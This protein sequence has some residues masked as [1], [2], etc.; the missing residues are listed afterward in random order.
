MNRTA[1]ERR[2]H[3]ERVIQRRLNVWGGFFRDQYC[4]R[5]EANTNERGYTYVNT[6]VL[7]KLDKHSILGKRRSSRNSKRKGFVVKGVTHR[8]WWDLYDRD[9]NSSRAQLKRDTRR[10]IERELAA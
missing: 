6:S 7:G 9:C 4:Q 5:P 10:E 2:H 3:R 8:H 1:A